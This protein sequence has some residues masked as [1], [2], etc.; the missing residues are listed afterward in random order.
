MNYF[1]EKLRELRQKPVLLYGM[2]CFALLIAAVFGVYYIRVIFSPPWLG[3]IKGTV[4]IFAILWVLYT[5][6]CVALLIKKRDISLFMSLLLLILGV[7]FTF[8]TPPNQVPDEQSHFLRA[9][10]MAQGELK[11]DENH[12]YPDDVN[13]FI[14]HF[15]VM[16]NN[17]Y[18]AKEGNTVYNR[19]S[20]YFS[21]INSGEKAPNMQIII[22]QTIPYIPQA[23]G[24]FIAKVLGFGA[25]AA[26]YF[27]RL[28][29]VVFFCAC[30]Y[31]SLKISGKFKI[32]LFT[33][34]ALPLMSFVTSSNNT[35]GMLFALMFLSFA[36]VLSDRFEL[37]KGIIFALSMAVLTTCKMSYIVFFPL[38]FIVKNDNW[39]VEIGKRKIKRW[40]WL[41]ISIGAFF[42]LYKGMEIYVRLFSNY[43][44]I[45]RTMTDSDPTKQLFF[46]LK[47]PIRYLAVFFDTLKNNGF[48]LFSGGLFGWLDVDIKLI[49]YLSP[50][51]VIL[52]TIKQSH[53]FSL[54][55]KPK[56]AMFFLCAILTYGVALTGLYLS[57]TPVS[58]PQ[59]I[60]LQ[61]RYLYPAFMG[62]V[63][64]IG[65][66]FGGFLHRE[67]DTDISCV[68]TSYIFSLTAAALMLMIYYLPVRA[69]VFIA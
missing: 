67:R 35:D 9:Y 42:V 11:F 14:L 54:E 49:S 59:I 51:V 68:A 26:F 44:V 43:G 13:S 3:Q 19:F 23:I 33:L 64:V 34:M 53:I 66:Y 39:C 22:F 6:F 1:K 12:I 7:V 41:L 32:V 24:I 31:F 65:Q 27:G 46:I 5:A 2:G 36:T 38:L 56:T 62:F 58:L 25:L 37:W 21:A 15:P 61:M 40:E 69:A 52:N 55:D 29:N 18:P 47:N 45:E 20:E 57:W 16:H 50:I 63:M 4:V 30:A 28:G 10:A 60:G 48:F 17:G 8:A